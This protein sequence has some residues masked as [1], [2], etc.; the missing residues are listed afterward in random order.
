MLYKEFRKIKLVK[1]KNAKSTVFQLLLMYYY[2]VENGKPIR[3]YK[4]IKN[5]KNLSSEES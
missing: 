5:C 1:R 3:K 4:T 2:G